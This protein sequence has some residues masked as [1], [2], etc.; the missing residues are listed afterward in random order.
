MVA[1]FKGSKLAWDSEGWRETN[2]VKLCLFFLLGTAPTMCYPSRLCQL[3]CVVPLPSL[4]QPVLCQ[5]TCL[6]LPRGNSGAGF[7]LAP[8]PRFV[9]LSGCRSIRCVYSLCYR[10]VFCLDNFSARFLHW[11]TSLLVGS[12]LAGEGRSS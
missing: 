4:A 12:L 2:L 9:W 11:L 7:K 3:A 1:V 6:R 8:Q 10:F 5:E